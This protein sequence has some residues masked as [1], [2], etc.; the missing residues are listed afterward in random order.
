MSAGPAPLPH[1]SGVSRW[2]NLPENQA[3]LDIALGELG[4]LRAELDL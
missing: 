2:L 3:R 1:A 4:R